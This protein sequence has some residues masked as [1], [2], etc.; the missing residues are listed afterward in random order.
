MSR[1]NSLKIIRPD[2]WHVHLREGELLECVIES[3]TR[4]FG[5]CIAMPN[6]SIPIT[7]SFLC[8]HY[9]NKITTLYVS[10]NK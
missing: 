1:F 3:T 7:N 2:D 8:N 9:K 5:R 10:Q 6:L 4:V